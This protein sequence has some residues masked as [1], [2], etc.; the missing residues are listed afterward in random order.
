MVRFTLHT[1]S[2]DINCLI[3]KKKLANLILF[4]DENKYE[5]SIHGH[6]NRRKQFVVEKFFVRNLD[7]FVREF[8]LKPLKSIA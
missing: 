7:S 1:S 5:L 4:L 3:S 8:V 6:Y 2:G